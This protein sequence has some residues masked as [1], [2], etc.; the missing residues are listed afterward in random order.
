LTEKK[1]DHYVV[2]CDSLYNEYPYG[3]ALLNSPGMFRRILHIT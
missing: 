3:V 1:C 2:L